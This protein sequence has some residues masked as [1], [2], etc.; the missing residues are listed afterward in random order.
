MRHPIWIGAFILMCVAASVAAEVTA[1]RGTLSEARLAI[2][3][4]QAQSGDAEAR[5]EL[6]RSLLS[7]SGRSR[8][9]ERAAY[10][11]RRLII[12]MDT[13]YALD[14]MTMLLELQDEVQVEQNENVD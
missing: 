11:L 8:N 3:E 9:V 7:G 12:E 4:A 1:N 14:A 6:A 10:W 2:L 5:M 13:E